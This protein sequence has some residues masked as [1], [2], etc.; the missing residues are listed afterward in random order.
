MTEATPSPTGAEAFLTRFVAPPNRIE[1]S[2]VLSADG[3]WKH[4]RPLADELRSTP[5][6]PTV[7]PCWRT[8]RTYWYALAF[9]EAQLSGL[10]EDL[11]AFVGPT[12]STF[13]GHRAVLDPADSVEAA[14]LGLTNGLAFKFT[15][16]RE[17]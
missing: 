1:L 16:P 6:R 3:K 13:R 5:V 12:Y 8:D 4:V 7:L 2:Q 14:V 10:R 11:M 15:G 17:Q 9:S